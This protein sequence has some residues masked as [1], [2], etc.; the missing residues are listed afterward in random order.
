MLHTGPGLSRGVVVAARIFAAPRY[1][2]TA[3][4]QQPAPL[5]QLIVGGGGAGAGAGAGDPM[6]GRRRRWN[7]DCRTGPPADLQHPT[8]H[9]TTWTRAAAPSGQT[10][11]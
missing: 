7:A 4:S 8:L 11:M 5:Y 6:L 10:N 3:A 2:D 1:R 9:H